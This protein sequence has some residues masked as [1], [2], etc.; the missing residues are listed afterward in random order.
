MCNSV[1]EAIDHALDTFDFERAHTVM[2]FLNWEWH[3]SNGVPS[4]ADM[5][6]A[7]RRLI[8]DAV[9]R[10]AISVGSGGFCVR[11]FRWKTGL[12]INLMFCVSDSFSE[13]DTDKESNHDDA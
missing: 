7:A 1:A 13:F 10:D 6:K 11:I 3:D 5:R 8:N 12:Q 9:T 4:I 2:K